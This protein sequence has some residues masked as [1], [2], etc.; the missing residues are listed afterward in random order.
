M[1]G[2]AWGISAKH[3]VT[4]SKLAKIPG[5]PCHM[6]YALRGRYVFQNVQDAQERRLQGWIG[7][8]DW[9]LLMSIAINLHRRQHEH[10]RWFDSGDL[11]SSSMLASIFDVSGY[12]PDVKHWLPTQERGMLRAVLSDREQ[13]GNI[14][15][16]VSST[17]VDRVKPSTTLTSSVGRFID[18]QGI[19]TCPSQSQGNKCGQCRACWD[20][21]VPHIRYLA[22]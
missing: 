16:R 14:T 9:H 5:T 8:P 1:P 13:P 21:N 10:F 20:P 7:D 19:H 3:C 18:E 17:K 11:Q 15:I 6:C 2:Y 4:G 22:H 12:T